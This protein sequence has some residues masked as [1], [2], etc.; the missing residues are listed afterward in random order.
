MQEQRWSPKLLEINSGALSDA[1]SPVRTDLLA[2]KIS[3]AMT[4]MEYGRLKSNWDFAPS[5]GTQ[6][7]TEEINVALRSADRCAV[8]QG[9]GHVGL[10]ARGS[11]ELPR[12]RFQKPGSDSGESPDVNEAHPLE[13]ARLFASPVSASRWW[14]SALVI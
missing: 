2:Q 6:I 7:S 12:A 9:L 3:Q 13:R 10:H 1:G 5:S 4:V 11:C 8:T 14:D